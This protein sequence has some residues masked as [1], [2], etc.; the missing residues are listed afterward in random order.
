MLVDVRLL[1]FVSAAS[2]SM[3]SSSSESSAFSGLSS[4]TRYALR[5]VCGGR[6][7]FRR[8]ELRR[9]HL[10]EVRR[11]HRPQHLGRQ[12]SQRRGFRHRSRSRSRSRFRSR[13]HH[14]AARAGAAGARPR[15]SPRALPRGTERGPR[16]PSWHKC[17]LKTT[18][19]SRADAGSPLARFPRPRTCGV[20][21]ADE[22][23]SD[24]D[25]WTT[26]VKVVKN[27][28]PRRWSPARS[29]S[30]SPRASFLAASPLV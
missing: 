17:R 30:L 23:D 6:S 26:D 28:S 2:V 15:A 11:P 16:P 24:S 3:S 5:M 18:P 14:A 22:P 1:P 7:R 13:S 27:F 10:A 21:E 12:Q 19:R 8:S 9:E 4:S 29:S 25:S 20:V